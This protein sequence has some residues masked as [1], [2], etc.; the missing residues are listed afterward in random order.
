MKYLLL[1]LLTISTLIVFSQDQFCNGWEEGYKDAYE[2]QNKFVGIIPFCPIAGI[3][4]K[5]YQTGYTLGYNKANKK[6]KVP[7]SSIVHSKNGTF[8]EGW[9]EGYKITRE[10]NN[11]FIGIIP[12]CPIHSQKENKYAIGY[13]KGIEKALKKIN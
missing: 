5:S 1:T 8:C 2:V 7:S 12:I 6:L 13:K 3:N 11:K 4:Q 9:E 10:E